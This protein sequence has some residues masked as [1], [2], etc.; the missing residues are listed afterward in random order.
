MRMLPHRSVFVRGLHYGIRA[1]K[2][3]S[4]RSTRIHDTDMHNSCVQK[5]LQSREMLLSRLTPTPFQV[6]RERTE[7]ALVEMRQRHAQLFSQMF[8]VSVRQI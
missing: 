5:A 6:P 7:R 1:V 3:S 4:G 2:Y 8:V